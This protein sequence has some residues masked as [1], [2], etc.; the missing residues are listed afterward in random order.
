MQ[1][2]HIVHCL[3][4]LVIERASVMN[5]RLHFSS[6]AVLFTT[7][8]S[9]FAY[10]FKS[11]IHRRTLLHTHM[12]PSTVS[13]ELYVIRVWCVLLE[14][15]LYTMKIINKASV[16]CT[17]IKHSVLVVR[18]SRAKNVDLNRCALWYV[19]FQSN[20][21]QTFHSIHECVQIRFFRT[22]SLSHNWFFYAFIPLT[23][24]I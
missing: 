19:L 22:P 15:E 7:A 17:G 8:I 9:G 16:C 24:Y 23:P 13:F 14:S 21:I 12:Y 4:I 1:L 5:N 2:K 11:L 10:V 20:C 3:S 18:I 6:F